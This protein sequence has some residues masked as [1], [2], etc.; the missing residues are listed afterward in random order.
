MALTFASRSAGARKMSGHRRALRGDTGEGGSELRLGE[1]GLNRICQQQKVPTSRLLFPQH[2]QISV[3]I[4]HNMQEGL[5]LTGEGGSGPGTQ[6]LS[7]KHRN[8]QYQDF[9][10]QHS[11]SGY[12]KLFP[13]LLCWWRGTRHLHGM[14]APKTDCPLQSTVRQARLGLVN[15]V[16]AVSS[17]FSTV[18]GLFLGH[19]NV[20][21]SNTYLIQ[22]YMSFNKENPEV[23]ALRQT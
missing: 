15:E 13:Y 12:S 5:T 23:S 17:A 18:S 16:T 21:S 20:H 11:T 3:S 14:E 22:S 7:K 9:V 6:H 10:P 4:L 19:T 8:E 2:S 1:R